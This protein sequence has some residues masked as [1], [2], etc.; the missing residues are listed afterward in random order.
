MATLD[1]VK[2]NLVA[3]AAED[4]L[5]FW[6]VLAFVQDDLGLR[7]APADRELT[8]EIVRDLLTD[9][10]LVAGFPIDEGPEFDAWDLPADQA[11]ARIEEAWSRLDHEPFTGDVAWFV[12][13]AKGEEWLRGG[14]AELSPEED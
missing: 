14:V 8:L 2:R 13:T 1:D 7:E 6:L 9:G 11:M 4:F 12:A 3:E 10:L 5:G